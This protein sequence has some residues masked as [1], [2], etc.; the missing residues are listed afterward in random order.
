[1]ING[2]FIIIDPLVVFYPC[3]SV[4]QI[5]SH[6]HNVPLEEMVGISRIEIRFLILYH[7]VCNSTTWWLLTRWA[8]ALWYKIDV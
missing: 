4:G 3:F 2:G 5:S 8:L 1:L 6:P 7:V